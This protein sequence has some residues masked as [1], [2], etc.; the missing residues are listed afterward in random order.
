MRKDGVH[1]D[2][3]LREYLALEMTIREPYDDLQVKFIFIEDLKD[4]RSCVIFK[5]HH[6]FGD[7]MAL[8][9]VMMICCDMFSAKN[10]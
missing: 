8:T 7:A 9:T 3:E 4:G 10:F 5:M 6:S 1:T 2:D